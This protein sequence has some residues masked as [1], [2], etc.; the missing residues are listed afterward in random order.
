MYRVLHPISPTTFVYYT[1][2]IRFPA[3]RRLCKAFNDGIPEL[4][5]IILCRIVVVWKGCL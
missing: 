2:K 4:Y 3:G 1:K 5:R